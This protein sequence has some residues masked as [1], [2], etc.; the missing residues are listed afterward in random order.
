MM[1]ATYGRHSVIQNLIEAGANIYTQ[2]K[3]GNTALHYAARSNLETVRL[4]IKL[5]LDVNHENSDG[6]TPLFQAALGKDPEIVNLLV[7]TGADVNAANYEG[8][9]ALMMAAAWGDRK[10]VEALID[11]GANVNAKSPVRKYGGYYP[12]A[13]GEASGNEFN[14][15][16]PEIVEILKKAGAI[17]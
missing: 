8:V 12:T 10:V 4:L 11:A 1:A 5:G 13:L 16:R 15:S 7:E 14:N 6:E 17:E 3:L 9:T 2:D